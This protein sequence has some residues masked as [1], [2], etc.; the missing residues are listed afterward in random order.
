MKFEWEIICEGS[1][2]ET[3]RAKV[4]GGW[5]ISCYGFLNNELQTDAMV[6]IPDPSHEWKIDDVD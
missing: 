5:V 2:F 1:Q 6:F 3:C 4:I